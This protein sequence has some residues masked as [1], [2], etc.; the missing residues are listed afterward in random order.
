ML[1]PLLTWFSSAKLTLVLI[2]LAVAAAALFYWRAYA[3]GEAAA[4]ADIVIVGMNKAIA[5]NVAKQ[6]ALKNPKPDRAHDP[7]NR[8]TWR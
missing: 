8:D 4:R 6:K 3:K 2:A 5:A 1:T 7:N